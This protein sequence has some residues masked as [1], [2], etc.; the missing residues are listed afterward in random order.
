MIASEGVFDM[1]N[2][3]RNPLICVLVQALF[4]PLITV[5][6]ADLLAGPKDP[7]SRAIENW[8][9]RL[10]AAD[11]QLQQGKWKKGQRKVESVFDDM[12]KKLIASEHTDMILG[13]ASYLRALA[14]AGMGKIRDARWDYDTAVHLRP[15]LDEADLAPYGKAGEALAAW[16]DMKPEIQL[17]AMIPFPMSAK[18]TDA[19]ANGR[20]G[21]TK[22]RKI[23]APRP[24]FPFA[25][26]VGCNE[27]LVVLS[28]I[29]DTGGFVKLPK[30][31][32]AANPMLAF[33]A[34]EAVREWRF[35]P[36]TLDGKWVNVAYNLSVNFR[37]P[38]CP[39][40]DG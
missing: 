1:N 29:I 25:Q 7:S 16:R 36:A 17:S 8:W 13:T 30:V 10:Q 27:G 20:E 23:R 39:E 9:E 38:H 12:E 37:Q 35:D 15:E 21:L 34:L 28:G 6:A 22:P 31:L 14:H 32:Q 19:S 24:E 2:R 26:R 40:S 5:P 18:A 11:A 3:L 33:A 4:W